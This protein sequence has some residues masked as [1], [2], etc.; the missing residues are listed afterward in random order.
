M[1]SENEQFSWDSRSGEPRTGA[2][3]LRLSEAITRQRE[4]L[5]DGFGLHRVSGRKRLGLVL[6]SLSQK[7]EHT[8]CRDLAY[9]CDREQIASC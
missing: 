6:E 4:V 3:A 1:R 8:G 2:S 5:Q 9:K 7:P